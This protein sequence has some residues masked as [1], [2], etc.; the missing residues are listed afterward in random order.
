M[1]DTTI[2]ATTASRYPLL[3]RRGGRRRPSV[4]LAALSS[5]AS[6][7]RCT[8]RR[9]ANSPQLPGRLDR[10][11]DRPA[12]SGRHR[13][14]QGAGMATPS[15]PDPLDRR[16]H[17]AGGRRA[18]LHLTSPPGFPVLLRHS[19]GQRHEREVIEELPVAGIDPVAERT[20]QLLIEDQLQLRVDDVILQAPTVREAVGLR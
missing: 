9:P 6:R 18:R 16:C 8:G 17:I 13:A 15:G 2:I 4:L 12:A 5:I 14:L 10:A 11:G 3:P 20:A 19:V 1:V 7:L